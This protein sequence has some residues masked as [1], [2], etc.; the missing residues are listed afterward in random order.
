MGHDDVISCMREAGNLL[1][2]TV[3]EAETPKPS[4]EPLESA[5]IGTSYDLFGFEPEHM[6]FE[7]SDDVQTVLSYDE[8]GTPL[9]DGDGY[10]P[11]TPV[12]KPRPLPSPPKSAY[13]PTAAHRRRW[14]EFLKISN[15]TKSEPMYSLDLGLILWTRV[16]RH[17]RAARCDRPRAL[18]RRSSLSPCASV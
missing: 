3:L 12:E 1:V 10:E 4:L 5:A 17:A 11:I 2:L 13:Q 16:P 9:G 15:D 14:M 18:S 6:D 7:E 8:D